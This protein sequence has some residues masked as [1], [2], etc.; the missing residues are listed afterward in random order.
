MAGVAGDSICFPELGLNWALL[1][2]SAGA[3]L[4][5]SSAG[6]DLWAAA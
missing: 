1:P 4:T 5:G 3:G 2:A 6:Q